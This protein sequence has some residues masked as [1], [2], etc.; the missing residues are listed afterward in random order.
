MFNTV[1]KGVWQESRQKHPL[2]DP[3]IIGFSLTLSNNVIFRRSELDFLKKRSC[4]RRDSLDRLVFF[5]RKESKWTRLVITCK[6][7]RVFHGRRVWTMTQT[8]LSSM[9]HDVSSFLSKRETWSLLFLT[10][11]SWSFE[12]D[13]QN[14]YRLSMVL[15]PSKYDDS[16]NAIHFIAKSTCLGMWVY[17]LRPLQ[18]LW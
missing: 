11:N 18:D 10:L 13:P 15:N 8:K 2:L 3:I 7:R 1:L 16:S 14:Y 5:P 17:V 6:R 9:K 4:I 12:E